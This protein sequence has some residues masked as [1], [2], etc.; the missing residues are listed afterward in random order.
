MQGARGAPAQPRTLTG[1]RYAWAGALVA[2]F[3]AAQVGGRAAAAS[4]APGAEQVVIPG[5]LSLTT[6]QNRGIAFGLL[7]R[8]PT[9]GT[10][11]IA[12]TVLA[13]VLYNRDA[14]LAGRAGQWG[15]GL[16]LGGALSNIVERLHTGY[17]FDYLDIH[18]LPVF[19]LADTAIVVGAALL[20]LAL[21]TGGAPQPRTGGTPSGG[22]SMDREGD[23]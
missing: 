19:N 3:A 6:V 17:V 20:V 10:V 7:A 22:G 5:V 9:A 13:V 12:L 14:W 11:A 16:I 1:A 4:L 2:A 15:F 21:R 23:G 18:V 8:L